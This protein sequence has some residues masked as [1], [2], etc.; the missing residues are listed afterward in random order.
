LLLRKRRMLW[1]KQ[2]KMLDFYSFIV[3]N[4]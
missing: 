3:Y 4:P 1:P 2:C